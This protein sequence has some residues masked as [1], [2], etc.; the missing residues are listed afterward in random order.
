MLH[1]SI[2][3]VILRCF[4]LRKIFMFYKTMM[5][6]RGDPRKFFGR[7]S[8]SK[9]QSPNKLL[10]SFQH[11]H[12]MTIF[13]PIPKPL[14]QYFFSFFLYYWLA[15]LERQVSTHQPNINF[16]L[17]FILLSDNALCLLASATNNITN[18]LIRVGLL[19]RCDGDF[20]SGCGF[21]SL[22]SKMPTSCGYI[23][24]FYYVLY[25]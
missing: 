1:F 21:P 14:Q 5:D 25:D 11:V 15:T 20:A 9:C 23:H 12:N 22:P 6:F 3:V 16:M 19:R 8:I 17:R 7:I 10:N 13:R 2:F 4:I 24:R 18:L